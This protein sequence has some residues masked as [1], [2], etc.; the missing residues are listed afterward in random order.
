MTTEQY[1]VMA[2]VAYVVLMVVKGREEGKGRYIFQ[3]TTKQHRVMA[4]VAV[5]L[6]WRREEKG[7]KG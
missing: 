6:W 4:S 2:S 7:A 5:V 3:M 1:R